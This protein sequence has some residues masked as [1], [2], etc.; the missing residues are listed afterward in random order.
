[1]NF[2]DFV[3]EDERKQQRTREPEPVVEEPIYE[4]EMY[5]EPEQEPEYNAMY[6]YE[7]EGEE[8]YYEQEPPK[9]IPKKPVQQRVPV[10]RQQVPQRTVVRQK[11]VYRNAMPIDQYNRPIQ[12]SKKQLTENTIENT[13]NTLTEAIKRKVDTIFYRFGIQGLEKLDEKILDTIEELQYPEQ[14][15]PIKKSGVNMRRVPPRKPV[16]KVKP[17]PIQD[18]EPEYEP[19]VEQYEEPVIEQAEEQV[20]EPIEQI[21]EQNVPVAEEPVQEPVQEE[22]VEEP[23]NEATNIFD[24]ATQLLDIDPAQKL[25]HEPHGNNPVFEQTSIPVP[26]VVQ[27]EKTENLIFEVPPVETPKMV[28]MPELD[29]STKTEQVEQPEQPEQPKRR[30]RKKETNEEG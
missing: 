15:T 28:T 1:M 27:P 11:P 9:V 4:Q 8:E 6:E 20:E 24:V 2:R 14:K 10:Y 23:K 21:V 19:V 16:R 22:E 30:R 12:I 17:L 26:P 5:Q 29:E 25:K 3:R 7:D 13:A 18:I